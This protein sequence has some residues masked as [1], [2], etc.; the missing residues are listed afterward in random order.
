MACTNKCFC[1]VALLLI[2]VGSW[3]SSAS[4]QD[5][6]AGIRFGVTAT[7]VDGDNL[8]GFDKAGLTAGLFVSR[9]LS[10]KIDV[11]MELV[12]IQKGSRKP[13]NKVDNSF[14][15]M[16]LNY[17]EV[18]LLLQYQIKPLWYLEAGAAMGVLVFSQEDYQLGIIEGL[19]AFKKLELAGLA[20]VHYRA[21]ENWQL[22]ARYSYSILPVRPFEG[23]YNINFFDRGQYNSGIEFSVHYRF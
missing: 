21:T 13:V 11:C 5:F 9:K 16:R 10:E 17:V 18:P 3:L 2:L 20:G 14:Y 22:G 7:Q 6:H 23:N 19:P 12:Y 1:I 4:A 15:R 8:S